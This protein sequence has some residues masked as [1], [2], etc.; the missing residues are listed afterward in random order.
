VIKQKKMGSAAVFSR[1]IV[2]IPNLRE[3]LGV[4][5]VVYSPN[6]KYVGRI[7]FVVGWGKKENTE[8]AK[9]YSKRRGLPYMRLEDGFLRSV[10]LGVEGDAPLSLVLDDV[11]I[12]YD[13]TKP[14]R[15]ENLLKE[16]N[17]EEQHPGILAR[18]RRCIDAIVKGQLSKYNN[19]P[20]ESKKLGGSEYTK[21]V[22]V[23]DQT[24]G[25]LSVRKGMLHSGGFNHIV[26][27][28][29]KENLDAEIIVKTHPDVLAGKKRGYLTG[30]FPG[31]RVRLI[32]EFMNPIGLIQQVDKV[33]TATSQMGFEALMAGKPVTCFG[34]PFYGGWGLTDDRVNSPRRNRR[35]TLEELFAAAYILYPRYIDPDTGKH[36]DIEAVI[37]YL[38]RQRRNFRQ[39]DGVFYCHGF[40]SWKRNYVRSYLRCPGNQVVFVRNAAQAKR[41]NFNSDSKLLVWGLRAKGDMQR[42][43]NEHNVPIW[44]MEDGFLRSIGLGSDLT[45]PASLV[46]D[47]RGIYYDPYEPSDLET[48]LETSVF[49]KEDLSR[50]K[51][52][53]Q[54]IISTCISK[55][56]VEA[57]R[58]LRLPEMGDRRVVLV[59]GQVEDDASIKLGCLDIRTN[60]GLLREVRK[61]RPRDFVVF[62]PHPDVVSGNR[63]GHLPWNRARKLCDKVVEDI[64]IASCLEVADEVHTMTSL[65]GFEALL[66]GIDV[67]VYGRPFYCGFGLTQDRYSM[68]RR[69]RKLSIDELVTGTL[70]KYPQY[71]NPKT[72]Y[73]TT[74]E[75]VVSDLQKERDN[76]LGTLGVR[77]DWHVRK[78]RQLI[79]ICKGI[80]DVR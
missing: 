70:I 62:K 4:E 72:G 39:N 37:E 2:R 47:T 64:S 73:F 25:D 18:S 55:Y 41:K 56:N 44:R 12:Y 63:K 42:L 65:V 13:A 33:Y 29:L 35:L 59:P 67:H 14:S 71:I 21:R 30:V 5:K 27:A 80:L 28:A 69:T 52:L 40:T 23:I 43:A 76:R 77:A 24:A 49:S 15:L 57:H 19:S 53:R 60:E 11:G 3:F 75:F 31:P 66:R 51:A 36:A 46:V 34:V 45:A 22:L 7:D 78:V 9:E 38:D 10:G 16:G 74:P 68:E 54:T 32:G 50:A 61:K 79:N 17:L 58:R 20:V 48:I 26:E 6:I 1:G 8:L